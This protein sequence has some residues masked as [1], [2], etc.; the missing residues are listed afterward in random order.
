MN[1]SKFK[2]QDIE[3]REA[4]ANDYE[5]L[6]KLFFE[7]SIIHSGGRPDCFKEPKKNDP[8]IKESFLEILNR[9]LSEVLVATYKG[10]AI[11]TLRV[12]ILQR[13]ETP[14]MKSRKE[15]YIGELVVKKE[16][17]NQGVGKALMDKA[18]EWLKLQNNIKEVILEVW[19]FNKE[20][21]EFYK[22][23]GFHTRK[24]ILSK[25]L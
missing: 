12:Q 4:T 22:S 1:N 18:Y 13:K 5:G 25:M 15:G 8:N 2:I 7:S 6:S 3:I 16:F 17:R 10:Q 14:S 9:N 11:G 19:S 21:L 23:L 20:A 24:H